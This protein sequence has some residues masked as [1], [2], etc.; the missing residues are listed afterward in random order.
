MPH[1]EVRELHLGWRGSL[2]CLAQMKAWVQ[3]PAL[4]KAIVRQAY[5]PRAQETKAGGLRVQGQGL[6]RQLSS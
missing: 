1:L 2:A 6:E 3:D 4:H 5:N